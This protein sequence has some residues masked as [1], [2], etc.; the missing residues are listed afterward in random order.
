MQYKMNDDKVELFYDNGKIFITGNIDHRRP[1]EIIS[2]F[3]DHI[4]SDVIENKIEKLKVDVTGLNF[5]NSSG[6][7][8]FIRWIKDISDYKLVFIINPD[9]SWQSSFTKMTLLSPLV[10]MEEI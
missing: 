3:Y 1:E 8:E 10:E 6:I 5:L 7:K 2:P 9:I 4:I